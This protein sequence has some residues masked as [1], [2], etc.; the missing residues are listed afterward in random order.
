MNQP[1]SRT[2]D[3]T[4]APYHIEDLASFGEWLNNAAA[5]VFPRGPSSSRYHDVHA[6]L[7]S[8]EEDD[9]GVIDEISQLNVVL[10]NNYHYET[11]Q[12]KIPNTRSHN[13]LASRL[14]T[15]LNE[16]ESKDNL[17]IV[18]YGGHGYMNDSRQCVWSW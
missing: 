14:T 11:A 1:T 9:L 5:A 2:H 12:W 4:M 13:S 15:F 18:Y 7:L 17:L 16:H 10:E 3:I 6:L 8:W